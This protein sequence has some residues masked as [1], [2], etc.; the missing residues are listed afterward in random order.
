MNSDYL[1]T[2]KLFCGHCGS[3]MV[4]ISG[5]SKTGDKHYYYS[6]QKHRLEKTCDKKNV[7][8]DYIEA[9]VLEKIRECLMDDHVIQWLVDGYEEFVIKVR[10][11]SLLATYEQDLEEVKKSLKNIMRAIEQGIFTDTTK[12]RLE[13]LEEERRV[14]EGNI[15][16]EK[17]MLV[18]T[19]KEQV[20]FWLESWRQG[21]VTD[22]KTA[23]RMIDTFVKAVYLYDTDGGLRGKIVCNYTGKNSTLE[24]NLDDLEDLPEAASRSVRISSRQV[25]QKSQYELNTVIYVLRDVFVLVTDL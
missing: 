18:D 12:E 13:E 20:Q 9:R 7:K 19:P 1:L 25:H 6:C 4:G 5:T 23:E 15:A 14:L 3:P 10:S 21:D 16:A 11:E 2:G 22:Q 8:R 24:F 17:A